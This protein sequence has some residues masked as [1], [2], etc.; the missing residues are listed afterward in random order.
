MSS[1]EGRTVGSGHSIFAT[2]GREG[3]FKRWMFFGILGGFGLAERSLAMRLL[4]FLTLL[5]LSCSTGLIVMPPPSPMEPPVAEVATVSLI[6]AARPTRTDVRSVTDAVGLSTM[7]GVVAVVGRTAVAL[8]DDA[9]AVPVGANGGEALGT[10]RSTGRRGQGA[11]LLTSNGV[12]LEQQGRLMRSPVSDSLPLATLRAIDVVGQGPTETWWLR[13]DD[14]VFRVTEGDVDSIVLT[15]P[16]VSGPIGAVV[17]RDATTA[18]VV[19]GERLYLIDVGGKTVQ[20]LARGVGEVFASARLAD[21]TV[22]FATRLGLLRVASDNRAVVSTFGGDDAVRDVSIDG[23]GALV[24][25]GGKLIS[26]RG[27]GARVLS[28]LAV[29]VIGGVVREGSGAVVALDGATLIRLGTT[30]QEEPVTF[31]EVKPFFAAHCVSCHAS[32]AN[33]APIID[34]TKY[35]TAKQWGQKSAAR[36]ANSASP[37]PPASSGLLSPSQYDVLVQWVAQGMLP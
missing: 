13:T 25:A 14:A 36:V 5:S 31:A 29:P 19:R 20:A 10:V 8:G 9:R 21:E 27:D 15:D 6:D 16:K 32:G 4:W 24:Q 26:V 33:Y 28:D 35:A 18:F 2:K 22:V 3:L 23:E 1:D 34:F 17:G 30:P 11:L 12:F 37:M 7:G